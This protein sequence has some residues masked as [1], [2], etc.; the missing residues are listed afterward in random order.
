MKEPVGQ[1][2]GGLA[3]RVC[4]KAR[5]VVWP[6]AAMALV[7]VTEFPIAVQVR[8]VEVDVIAADG[9]LFPLVPKCNFGT[10]GAMQNQAFCKSVKRAASRR[11]WPAN[12][13]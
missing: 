9:E 2:G 8:A 13:P 5:G 7:T 1:P 11:G 3:M 12:F 6:A 4:A 10:R